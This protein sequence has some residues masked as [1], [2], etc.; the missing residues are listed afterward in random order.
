MQTHEISRRFLSYFTGHGHTQVPSASLILEDPTLLFVNAGMV[1]FKPYFLG[2]AP[3]PWPRATS[4]QK[5]VRTGDIDEVGKTT[6]HNTFFQMAGNFSFGDYFKA[7]AIEHAWT[8]LT[9]SQ[10]SGGYGFAPDR[11]WATVYDDD[12]E[13]IGL[14]R[15]ITG[16]PDERIQ[17]RDG[18]D[19]YWD[20]GVPGPGGPCSE[21]YYDRGPEHG[22]D[23]GPVADE[24]RY[25][26]VWNLVFMQDIRGEDSP[27]YGHKPIG[28]LPRKNIDT[29]MGIERVAALLQGVDNVYETDL[30]RPVIAKAEEM[31]GRRY[32]AGN[33]VDDVRFRVIADHA[34]SGMMIIGDGVTPG[35]EARGYVL[36]RLLR[37]IVRSVRL[38]GVQE[39]VLAEFAAV[40][41]DAMA[42]SYPELAADFPR[43]ESIMRKEEETFLATLSSGSRIFDLAADKLVEDGGR[44]LPGDKAFQLHDTY[45]F[46]IDL[47]L[48]MAAERGLTVDETGFR[49][50]MAEQRARAKADAAARKTGHGDQSVYRDLLA[51]G[52]TVFTGYDELASEAR[53]IGLVRDGARVAGAAEGE[54][55]EV[56]LD[57]TPLYA[58]SGGQESDAGTITTADGVELEVLDVQKVARKL[59]V[60]QARV[61]SGEITEGARVEAR[62]DPEWR[63]GARQG[64]SGTHVVHAAL[65]Q[66]LGPTALQSGSYNKPGYLRLDF[67]WSG[68]LSPETRSEIEEVSNLAVR[69][70]LPVR[71][72]YTDMGGAQEMGAVALFGETYDDTVRVVEIGGPWSRELCGGT[73]VEHSSQIGPLTLVGESSVGSGNR[74][75][76]AYVGME[77]MRYLAKERALVQGLAAMLK[78][79]D[80]EVPGRVEALVERLR[81]AEK[82][83]EKLRAGQLL[84][85]AGTLVEQAEDLGGTALVALKVPDG[86]GG[87]DLRNLAVEVRNRLG[88]R[89]GVVALFSPGDGGKVAFVVATTAAAR[90][91]GLAAGKLVPAFAPAIAA[92]GGGKPDLAQGGGANAEGVGE[93]VTL[94]RRA[95]VGA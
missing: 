72:V 7:Q 86:I 81:A 78:V 41:R 23:G 60:H 73:H 55:V 93:A 95:L 63:I 44:T 90:D 16:L 84:S 8:L 57:R 85:S 62:V 21:I 75:I 37:R 6:R 64:H 71:V 2:D 22:R 59:W 24:D 42:P 35:N 11:L 68:A 20:M 48:E 91:A 12:D 58:E 77:A 34:R 17:R 25:L 19:N 56:V 76:E 5:C 18:R 87:G 92:R 52:N 61:R 82:E 80:A 51:R 29:G 66:V 10:D 83:L 26:E 79:P 27:K 88:S 15:K 40:V 69:E 28:T 1:Q 39:P 47:T 45:G 13:A 46:P 3:A 89:P 31:S 14:W 33:P 65:R 49:E 38:L 32:G 30:I 74:R 67:A 54:I 94:L 50:L 53:V 9:D 43:I 4:V 70:D 36:R